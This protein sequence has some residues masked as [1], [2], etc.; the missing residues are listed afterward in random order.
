M[1]R[2]TVGV[3]FS[4]RDDNEENSADLDAFGGEGTLTRADLARAI[5]NAVGI[6][7]TEATELI[8]AVLDEIFERLV[9]REEVK[10][11]SFGTF[12]IREKRERVG[13]NPKTG[14]G[15][16]ISARLVVSFKPS[17]ILRS[18]VAGD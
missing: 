12:S 18:R 10:L 13:R 5:Q 4:D 8:G 17:N 6:S 16:R 3:F 7:R 2:E 1:S 14:A 15:A 11:S 9:A